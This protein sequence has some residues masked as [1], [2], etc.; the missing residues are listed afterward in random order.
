[1]HIQLYKFS[2]KKVYVSFIIVLIFVFNSQ[3]HG[4]GEV[5]QNGESGASIAIGL[6]S[7][8]KNDVGFLSRLGYNRKRKFEAGIGLIS[9][10][11]RTESSTTF[12]P[13][14]A[15]Y[16]GEKAS[17]RFG[18][19]YPIAEESQGLI[20]SVSL[21]NPFEENAYTFSPELSISYQE[22]FAYQL[23]LNV[24][25]GRNGGILLGAYYANGDI[26][27]VGFSAGLLFDHLSSH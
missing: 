26:S 9:I 7:V 27:T 14:L 16:I 8:P 10:S 22:E 3:L 2:T 20:Y 25:L 23:G 4:Q 1:M 21:F 11:T 5:L 17:I 12:V 18:L 6:F 19:S 13:D 24:K 15:Y